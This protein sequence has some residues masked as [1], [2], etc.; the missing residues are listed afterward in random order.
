MQ[1]TSPQRRRRRRRHQFQHALHPTR[2]LA[3]CIDEICAVVQSIIYHHSCVTY[4]CSYLYKYSYVHT[5]VLHTHLFWQRYALKRLAGD[6][7]TTALTWRVS[8]Q[9]RLA[10]SRLDFNHF[11]LWGRLTFATMR[12]ICDVSSCSVI[13]RACVAR[14]CAPACA[15]ARSRRCRRCACVQR[16]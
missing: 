8:V 13:T 11:R 5:V 14:L 9:R 2:Q 1:S 12:R 4:N 7:T 6:Q 15:H 10:G 3:L 16:P